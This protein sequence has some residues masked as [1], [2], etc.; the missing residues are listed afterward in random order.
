MPV[1]STGCTEEDKVFLGDLARKSEAAQRPRVEGK[2][3]APIGPKNHE[4]GGAVEQNQV[5]VRPVAFQSHWGHC[6]LLVD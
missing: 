4:I 5:L 2:E 6:A 3:K 1:C